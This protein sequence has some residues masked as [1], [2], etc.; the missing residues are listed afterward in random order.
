VAQAHQCSIALRNGDWEFLETAELKLAKREIRKLNSILDFLLQPRRASPVDPARAHRAG[1]H[2]Q[3]S[4]Q[5]GGRP[6][7]KYRSAHR[8]I[9]SRQHPAQTPRQKYGRT[10]AAGARRIGPVSVQPQRNK[11]VMSSA[12]D[13]APHVRAAAPDAGPTKS[14][15]GYPG[16]GEELYSGAAPSARPRNQVRSIADAK[17]GLLRRPFKAEVLLRCHDWG[18]ANGEGGRFATSRT[19]LLNRYSDIYRGMRS[20]PTGRLK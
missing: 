10:G 12:E 3:R 4:F 2:R 5:Q 1:S 19:T 8:R 6:R 7:A 13:A 11:A 16:A 18:L 9:S 15:N 14:S 17:L 20:A